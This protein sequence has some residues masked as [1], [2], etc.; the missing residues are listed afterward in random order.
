V[1]DST[2]VLLVIR[3]DF[4]VEQ[5]SDAGFTSDLTM[6][7]VK[8]RFGVAVPVANKAIRS[9][10]VTPGGGATRTSSKA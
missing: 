6:F 7:R 3:S 8:G 4:S 1:Y 5:S 9:L 2:R 10:T